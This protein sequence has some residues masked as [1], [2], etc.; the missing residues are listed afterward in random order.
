[1]HTR[2]PRVLTRRWHK[3][4]E[5]RGRQRRVGGRGGGRVVT[6]CWCSCREVENVGGLVQHDVV[7]EVCVKVVMLC[8]CVCVCVCVSVCVCV[9][10]YIYIYIYI[11]YLQEGE[12]SF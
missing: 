11:Y 1:M 7:A 2:G 10:L 4:K 6:R 5:V 9:C 3:F 12:Q 8:V